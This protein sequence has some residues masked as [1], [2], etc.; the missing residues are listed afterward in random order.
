RAVPGG[1]QRPLQGPRSPPRADQHRWGHPGVLGCLAD[2]RP[3]TTGVRSVDP[4]LLRHAGAAR[5]YLIFTVG[6]GLVVTALVLAQAGLRAS[7]LAPAARGTGVAVLWP[8]LAAL[9]VV[10]AARAAATGGSEA[11]ALRAAAAVKAQ[12]RGALTAHTLRLGPAWLGGQQAG[13]IATVATKG[14]G[15]LDPDFARVGPPLVLAGA[16]AGGGGRRGG[17]RGLDL[18]LGDRGDAAAD[19]GVRGADRAAHQGPHGPPVAAAGHPR[20]PFPRRGRGAAHD[21]AVRPGQRP[22][23]DDRG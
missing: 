10:V 15:A 13:Q 14:L 23:D 9:L 7:A 21:Q 16:G 22:G 1:H 19:P 6:L 2:R 4:R 3:E 20:R 8:A 11:V 5:G 17:G 18:R 12:L